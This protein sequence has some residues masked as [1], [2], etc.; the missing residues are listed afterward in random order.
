MFFCFFLDL[1]TSYPS[2]C[3]A[4]LCVLSS[5]QRAN[6]TEISL[7]HPDREYSGLLVQ[8]LSRRLLSSLHCRAGPELVWVLFEANHF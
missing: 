1:G 6:L 4:L 8:C 2:A 7:L 5:L 3:V